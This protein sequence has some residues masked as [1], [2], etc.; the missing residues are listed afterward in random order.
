VR[1]ELKRWRREGEY[2]R[3]KLYNIRSCER[4]KK[5]KNEK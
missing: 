4:K 1:R 3:K 5:E 2:K